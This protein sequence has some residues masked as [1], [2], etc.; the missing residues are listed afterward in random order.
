M[1]EASAIISRK[2]DYILGKATGNAHNLERSHSMYEQIKRIGLSDN[3]ETRG[4]IKD[5]LIGALK[6]PSS[7]V[8]ELDKG[9]VM[10]E[11]ILS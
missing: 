5:N 7:I 4:I 6:N 11:T 1:A 9:K 3:P 10:R 8:K 2:S